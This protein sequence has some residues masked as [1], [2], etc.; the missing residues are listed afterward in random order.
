MGGYGE[1]GMNGSGVLGKPEESY[2]NRSDQSIAR[3]RL[4]KHFQTCNNIEETVIF[5]SSAPS[6]NRTWV[7]CDQLLCYA[8]VLTTE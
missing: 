7:L 1:R 5:M 3:Q 8:T 6:K 2:C 4:N